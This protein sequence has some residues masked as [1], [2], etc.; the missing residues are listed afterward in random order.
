VEMRGH[1]VESQMLF[2]AQHPGRSFSE[3]V[4]LPEFVALTATPGDPTAD[5]SGDRDRA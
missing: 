2:R 4:V 3:R 1:P 5:V